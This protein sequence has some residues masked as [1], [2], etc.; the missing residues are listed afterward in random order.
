MNNRTL[1]RP[2]FRMGGSAEGIT[3]G[4]QAP[5]Q[6]YEGGKTVE[7]LNYKSPLGLKF[8]EMD[9]SKFKNSEL[10]NKLRNMKVSDYLTGDRTIGEM[11]DMASQ[12]AYKPRGTNIN[13]FLISTGLDLVSRPKQGNIF[14]QVATSAKEPLANFMAAKKEAAE[15]RYASESDLFKSMMEGQSDILASEAESCLLYTSDAAD[16]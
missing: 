9:L 4:L 7:E 12:L 15:Q 8:T 2:M 14:S 13:D 5:R 1:R 11:K 3:S 6:N 10:S 16:E